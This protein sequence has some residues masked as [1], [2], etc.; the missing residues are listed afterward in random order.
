[1]IAEHMA[2][3][4]SRALNEQDESL[5]LNQPAPHFSLT[6][7]QGQ[8]I[9]LADYHGRKHIILWFSRGF[10]CPFCRGHMQ[11]I[12]AGYE[13]LQ[14]QDI[15]VVQVA[16]NLLESAMIFF[17]NDT[18]PPYPFVCDPDKRLFA[19]YGIGDQGVLTA[20]RNAFVSFS[21][22]ALKKEFGKTVQAS[23]V[24]VA[25]K[26]F[27][28]RLHHHA[29]TALDQAVFFINKEGVLKYRL[30]VDALKDIPT[31]AELLTL[32]QQKCAL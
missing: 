11:N 9:N 7:I 6:S 31:A 3:E 21:G 18:H 10:T 14:E 22:A 1:M 16:P 5:H 28:R 27:L 19:T 17:R 2:N 32:F 30:D 23:W 20:T 15:E 25:N 12:I 13:A 26:N 4:K 8:Q 29:L 24:D